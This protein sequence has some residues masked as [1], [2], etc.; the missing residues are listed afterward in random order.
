MT[1][2]VLLFFILTSM[3][4]ITIDVMCICNV[5]VLIFYIKKI[6]TKYYAVLILIH[7]HVLYFIVP[8]GAGIVHFKAI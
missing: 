1:K 3:H 7:I 4:N 6:E 2:A 5:C 8:A